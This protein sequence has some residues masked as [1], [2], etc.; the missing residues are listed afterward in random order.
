MAGSM[1][2][3]LAILGLPF[4]ECRAADPVFAANLRG[5]RSRFLLSQHRNN[6]LF[7]EPRLLHTRLPQGD[8]FYPFLEEI[9]GLRSRRVPLRRNGELIAWYAATYAIEDRTRTERE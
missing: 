7:R 4:V 6:P 3:K 1:Y 8:G 5:L 2:L 9:Q